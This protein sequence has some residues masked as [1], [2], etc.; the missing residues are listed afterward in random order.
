MLE[1]ISTQETTEVENKNGLI[2][3]MERIQSKYGYLP[4]EQLKELS[5]TTGKSLVDIYA[6]ATFYKFFRLQP[7]GKHLLSV[8]LGTACH[9]RGGP[10][11]ATEFEKQLGISAGNM[12][13]DKE[14]TL[15]TLTCLGA[16]ALGPV[17]VCDGHYISKVNPNMVNGIIKKAGDGFEPV[18]MS[19]GE[20]SIHVSCLSC[21][22]SLM[23][24]DFLIDDY[25]SIRLSASFGKK[26]GSLRLSSVYGS[27]NIESEHEIS[28]DSVVN[29]FCPHCH[30]EM[31]GIS[32][33]PECGERMVLMR[34]QGGGIVQICP[35]RGCNGHLLDLNQ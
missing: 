5:D 3:R 27:Y 34:V 32:I 28:T 8:C 4:K 1:T 12:T 33:C 35:R 31:K 17:V 25:P 21:N 11:V 23:D 16:C 13:P 18:K 19:D 2:A 9:V 15:E 26:Y 22:H 20:F 10:E 6:V 14:F 7:R 30:V 24:D 29:I